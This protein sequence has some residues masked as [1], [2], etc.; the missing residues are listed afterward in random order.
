MEEDEIELETE[1]LHAQ[2]PKAQKIQFCLFYTFGIYK[3][4]SFVK[5]VGEINP[6]LNANHNLILVYIQRTYF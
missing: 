3:L 4:K 5:N 6:S 2:I 1:L